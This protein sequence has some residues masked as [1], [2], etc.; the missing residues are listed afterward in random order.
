MTLMSP[1][2]TMPHG[3]ILTFSLSIVVTVFYVMRKLVPIPSSIIHST[4]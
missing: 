1:I 4:V 3:Y 2:P